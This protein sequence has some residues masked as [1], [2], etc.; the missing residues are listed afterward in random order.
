MDEQHYEK[1]LNI[2]TSGEQKIFNKDHHYNRY[3][4]TSYDVLNILCENYKFKPSDTV[5]DFGCG[6]GRFNF[7]LNFFSKCNTVGIEMNSFFYQQA[8]L[9]KIDYQTKH[10]KHF[11]IISF[12]NCLAEEYK[13]ASQDNIFYFFNPFSLQIFQKVLKNIIDSSQK[14]PRPITLILYYP[15]IDY[16]N[17]LENTPFSLLKEI[18]IEPNYHQDSRNT[19]LIYIMQ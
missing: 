1:L 19:F 3:E 9:N 15:D 4:A 6:K 17:H 18:K 11:S 13:I 7:Y 12:E 10:K 16:I 8:L 2:K 14:T 5:I